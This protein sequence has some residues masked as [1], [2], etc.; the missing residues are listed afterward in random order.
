MLKDSVEQREA[1]VEQPIYVL[2]AVLNV[3]MSCS[4]P[5]KFTWMLSGEATEWFTPKDSQGKNE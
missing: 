2:E 3:K 1:N 5:Q 4:E